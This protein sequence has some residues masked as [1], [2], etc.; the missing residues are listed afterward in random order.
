MSPAIGRRIP[1]LL[2]AVFALSLV[3]AL[4]ACE[5]TEPTPTPS[6]TATPTTTPSPVPTATATPIP[7]PTPEPTATATAEPTP[8]ATPTPEP[9]PLATFTLS[10]TVTDSRIEGLP[11]SAAVVRADYA[12]Q[13]SLTTTK[14][15]RFR[16]ENIHGTVKLTVTAEPHFKSTSTQLVMD[17]DR[18]L[19]FD[20]DH[21]GSPPYHGTVFITSNVLQPSDPTSLQSVT[22]IGRGER[23]IY[24][25]RPT[26][27]ITVNAYLFSV[28]YQDAE[29]EFQVN[30]EFGSREA[31][32]TEVDT[33]AAALG[34]LPAVLLSRAQKVQINAGDELFGGNWHDKSFLIH[35]DQGRE[36]IRN[37]YLEEVFIHEAGHISL[38][39]AHANSAEWRAAQAADGVF[40]SEYARDFPVRED[41]AE[42]I[43]PYFALQYLPE[44]LTDSD[45]AAILSAIPNRL[46]YFDEQGFDMSPYELP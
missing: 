24:D 12:D 42:S 21:T 20:L 5:G 15:G 13:T 40:I 46:V 17:R 27:W 26:A 4:A 45:R 1:L 44:R 7:V 9:T 14:D 3:L 28:R 32:R 6:Q 33:Y 2:I 22:Y 39:G 8:T 41:I 43:L 36:Y 35:T 38:D 19:D 25:R 30:P 11:I 31:A 29:L 34:R 10:G 37:G 16:I 23:A 18:T